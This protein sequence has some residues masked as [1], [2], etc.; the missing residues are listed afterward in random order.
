[1]PEATGI[2][3][4]GWWT[5]AIGAEPVSRRPRSNRPTSIS[6]SCRLVP[7]CSKRER[8]WC[9]RERAGTLR[10]S[11]DA[12]L[13]VRRSAASESN[14]RPVCGSC[15]RAKNQRR[16]HGGDGT[17]ETVPDRN[18][19]FEDETPSIASAGSDR[20]PRAAISRRGVSRAIPHPL[21]GSYGEARPLA[22]AAV[23]A[24]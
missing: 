3:G 11:A 16:R 9:R 12:M 10:A 13:C 15:R 6:K 21:A 2:Y 19:M 22:P 20:S 7:P 8:P 14:G 18:N 4:G 5:P 24:C 23:T 17:G 1:M